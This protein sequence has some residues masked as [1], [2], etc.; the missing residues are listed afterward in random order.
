[1]PRHL[2]VIFISGHADVVNRVCRQG[3]TPLFAKPIDVDPL[4]AR[5]REM[6]TVE[7]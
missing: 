2:P 7:C 5:V 1:M 6:T 4:L 3:E